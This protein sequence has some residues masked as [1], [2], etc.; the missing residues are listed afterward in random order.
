VRTGKD[1]PGTLRMTRFALSL[2]RQAD[3]RGTLVAAGLQVLGAA[4]ALGA[5]LATKLALQGL[6]GGDPGLRGDLLVGL[7]LLAVT[8]A[9]S[10]SL[11]AIQQQHQRLLGER[12]SQL[13]WRRLLAT[14][15]AVPL[16]TW[17]STNFMDRLDRVRAN[18]LARP[19]MVMTSIFQMAGAS[20][21]VVTLT[22]LLFTL[23]PLLVP[24]LLGAGLPAVV[25]SRIASRAEFN[26]AQETN[27]RSRRRLYLKQLLTGRGYAAEIRAFEAGPHLAGVHAADDKSFEDAL[28]G[29]V[30]LRQLLGLVGVI[31]SALGLSAALVVIVLLVDADRMT[32]S[33]AGAAAIATRLL[34]AQLSTVFGSIGSLI[35]SAPFMDDMRSFLDQEPARPATGSRRELIDEL[36]V[37]NV[38]FAYDHRS[39]PALDGVS[40][41]VRP[42]SIVALVGE[43][44]CG[45]TT[46]AKLVAG[47]YEPD[48]GRITWDG[49]VLPAPDL[50]A[51]VTV[52]FQDF[53]RYQF[54]A[55]RNITIAQPGRANE[56][57]AV[58]AAARKADIDG[59][60]AGLPQGYD[61]PIGLELADGTDL[62]GGQWQRLALARAIYRDSPV[63][64]LD[65]P[66]AAMDPR[67]E[68]EL[69][70]DMRGMLEGRAALLISHRYSSVRLADRIYVL[71]QGRVIE[72]GSHDELIR[73]G[74]RYAEL[75][76]LQAAAYLR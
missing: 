55:R 63:V 70:K 20:L 1:G 19:V 44:G 22:A 39:R 56:S 30:F 25:M 13:M 67:A 43:N 51:G 47:L 17:N 11:G 18:A 75:Y 23:E 45:K 64:V 60:L 33:E 9:M 6:L 7:I 74:G 5:V 26:F 41:S 27:A 71:D 37:E 52:L 8:T 49:E 15:V 58:V 61:T 24:I 36:K 48:S 12:V 38:S 32:L 69:F 72:E 10:G 50:R 14:C 54:T 66:T 34:G 31:F 46:L 42:H 62:S 40:I 28:R 76:A 29:Q 2:A 3:A 57:H 73:A 21:G 53:V 16:A 68:F 4:S 65:E 59:V 35:E